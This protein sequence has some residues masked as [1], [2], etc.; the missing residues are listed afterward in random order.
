MITH[1]I[2]KYKIRVWALTQCVTRYFN[3]VSRAVW[4]IDF[5]EFESMIILNQFLTIDF[6][7][8]DSDL[9]L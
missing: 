4:L 6:W 9:M 2:L 1:L 5:T 7:M 8:D 3:S